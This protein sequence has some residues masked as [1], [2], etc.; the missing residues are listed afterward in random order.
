MKKKVCIGILGTVLDAGAGAK[1]W[2]KWRPSVGLFQQEDLLFDRF[3]LIYS[4]NHKSLA[5]MIKTDI[6]TAS[7][8]TDVKLHE[9]KFGDPWDF[10]EVYALLDTFARWY[11]F[12]TEKEEYFVHITTGTHV[13][14]ICLFLI[15]ESHLIPGKL[16][17]THPSPKGFRHTP[18]GNYFIIDLDLS[19]YDKLASRFSKGACDDISFLK[20]GIET[21]NA[22]F[23][24]LIERIEQVAIYSKEPLL[25]MGPTG[26]GKSLL[27]RRIYELKKQRR[28]LVGNFVEINCATIR[29]D[30]AM[31]ALFGHVKGAFTGA[32][33]DRPGL[34]KAADKGLLF[35]DEVGE[36]G[37][38]EQAML[39]RA[40]EEGVF[41]PLG[42]DAESESSFQLICGTNRD[43]HARVEE[44]RFRED[45]LSRINLWTFYLPGLKDR[46]EDIEP[47]INYELD[48]FEHANNLHVTFSREAKNRFL[49]FAASDEG[50]WKS[51]FRDLNGAIIRMA[52][53]AQG[54]RI[55]LEIVEEE[56]GRLKRA[57]SIPGKTSSDDHDVLTGLLGKDAAEKI[58]S[59]EVPQL[60]HVVKVCRESKTISGAGRKLFSVSRGK[61][62]LVNDADRLKKYL[63]RF[64]LDWI[65]VTKTS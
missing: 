48:K 37:L 1:R 26:A 36:L 8:E 52:T 44:G 51:N 58:D 65:S 39:L 62:K 6:K 3:E 43:L 13:A 29:G 45:L 10:E 14:Q 30:A 2:D 53:L 16:I 25:L 34:L 11:P 17:Q 19:K 59:F 31:S 47:N 35:L 38:D 50:L 57:W 40:L 22:A 56:I 46:P 42:G 24:T 21:K 23:N 33:K 60:I 54:G 15:V 7:P 5:E 9:V 27:A 64:G 28:Q 49:T 18:A 55:T 20:S 12:E 4:V 61:R 32:L 41:M 63:A